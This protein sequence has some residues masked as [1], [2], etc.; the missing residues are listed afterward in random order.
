MA[1][2]RVQT[3]SQTVYDATGKPLG[4]LT[5]T[6]FTDTRPGSRHAAPKPKPQA[7]Q[8][9]P[10][11]PRPIAARR[12]PITLAQAMTKLGRCPTCGSVLQA[13]TCAPVPGDVLGLV[14]EE[15]TRRGLR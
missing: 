13:C 5:D 3:H 15:Q 12:A 14:I 2:T 9:Q 7:P 4:T 8:P 6:Y 1:R 11:P 10:K